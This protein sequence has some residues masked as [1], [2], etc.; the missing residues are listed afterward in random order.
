MRFNEINNVKIVDLELDRDNY[1]FGK[2]SDEPD[3]I[4]KIYNHS[5]ENF[6]NIMHD[7]AYHDLGEQLL[8]FKHANK[9]TVMDGNRR[10]SILKILN[11][12]E[13]APNDSIK[14]LAIELRKNAKCDLNFV[15][16]FVSDNLEII[17]KTVYERHAATGGI[18]RIKWSAYANAR[19][20]YDTQLHG[21]ANWIA[22]AL[23]V[24]FQDEIKSYDDFIADTTFSF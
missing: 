5:P 20:R 3:C 14:N 16:A 22:I 17:S 2:A 19:F 9:L 1:R 18:G 12:P 13:L 15:G 23:L 7:I 4:R 8:V 24:H 11:N 10:V 21:D 6:K